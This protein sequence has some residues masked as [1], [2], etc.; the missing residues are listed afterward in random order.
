[1]KKI[2][3]LITILTI[4]FSTSVFAAGL[5]VSLSDQVSGVTYKTNGSSISGALT[6]S[7]WDA[8]VG[9][10]NIY[11]ETFTSGI[12]N[13]SWNVMLGE[14]SSNNL[15]LEYGKMYYKDY[16]INLEDADFTMVNGSTAE[17][18]FFYSPLGDINRTQITNDAIDSTK[19]VDSTIV[20]A[21]ISDTT[22]L[23][24]SNITMG[25]S[26]TFAL[27]E[28]ISNVVDGVLQITGGLN[29]TGSVDIADNISVGAD[30][31]SITNDAGDGLLQVGTDGVVTMGSNLSTRYFSFDPNAVRIKAP[32]APTEFL[33]IN[34]GGTDFSFY[35]GGVFQ[36]PEV[37]TGQIQAV[38]ANLTLSNLEGNQVL[39]VQSNERVG[40]L[41]PDARATLEVNGTMI[42]NGSITQGDLTGDSIQLNAAQ[43]KMVFGSS[44]TNFSI[45]SAPSTALMT[46]DV[47]LQR[48]HVK[49]LALAPQ[50]PAPE[51]AGGNIGQ[52]YYD[53]ANG[54][55]YGCNSTGWRPLN[56]Q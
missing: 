19:I 28:I 6:V 5:N 31:F 42:V 11:N 7:I 21:D 45:I 18:Q 40:I 8:I 14:N 37:K 50:T 32:G 22:N 56:I 41:T 39:K 44:I 25:S 29:V 4:L 1:M 36:S 3:I 52:I 38:E 20:D 47:G 43:E 54:T 46:F 2:L 26:I 55:F 51:C 15:S 17:R 30:N 34:V 27:G 33:Y 9:G 13:G 16:T 53:S 24:I 35:Y 23:T 10:T 48:T 49:N 12:V